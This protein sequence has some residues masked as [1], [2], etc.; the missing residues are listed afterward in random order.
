MEDDPKRPWKAI[1]GA[2]FAALSASLAF[3]GDL[4]TWAI[5]LIT[6]IVAGLAT[7]VVPNPKV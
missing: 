2:V 6:C 3:A 4:P 7:Y 5:I 1:A